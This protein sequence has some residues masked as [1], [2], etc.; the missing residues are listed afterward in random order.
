VVDAETGRAQRTR[1][2]AFFGVAN[3]ND[4]ATRL[5]ADHLVI[6]LVEHVASRRDRHGFTVDSHLGEAAS[7]AR[8]IE[9][10][11]DPPALLFTAS[12]GMGFPSGAAAQRECQGALLCQD[13]AGPGT[14]VAREHYFAG[15]DLPAHADLRGMI[16]VLF[17]CFGGG[18][19]TRDEFTRR[20][21]G[22]AK[23]QQLAPASL[24]ARLP[25]RMLGHAAGGA[26]AVVAHIDRAWGSTFLWID[27][28]GKGQTRK[29]LDVFESMLDGVLAGK[30]LG[31]AMEAFNLRYAELAADL[32]ERIEQ[33]QLYDERYED[34]ELAHMWI[35]NNDARNYAVIGDPAVRIPSAAEH[36]AAR[37][38]S[39]TLPGDPHGPGAPEM[40]EMTDNRHELAVRERGDETQREAIEPPTYGWFGG[41]DD[42]QP[43][44]LARLGNKLSEVLS[45][46]LGDAAVLE[47]KTYTSSDLQSIAGGEALSASGARLRAY[48]RC[49][50]DGDTEVCVPVTAAGAV[51]EPLWALHVEM[52]KQAQAHRA[53]L[54][55]TV[56]SVFS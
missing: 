49:K 54:L 53:E 51:D 40:H 52:V 6:P 1:R 8:L 17:A 37:R 43:G 50:L 39:I 33:I 2:A 30:R 16:G 29:H 47:V 55:K 20:A 26:L 4:A 21:L 28:Q 27:A 32:A 24:I 23:A 13:W 11:R 18:T 31:Y 38:E 41:K 22:E 44:A 25:Q 45:E 7:R 36:A 56:L 46:V 48:T 35:C 3:P 9:L 15:A 19:P 42:K 12:H 14:P 34:S 5:S 10:L